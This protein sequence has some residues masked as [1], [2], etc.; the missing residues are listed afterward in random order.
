LQ[1]ALAFGLGDVLTTNYAVL[2]NEALAPVRA[3][4]QSMQRAAGRDEVLTD[5]FARSVQRNAGTAGVSSGGGSH[6]SQM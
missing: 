2:S 6:F 5:L 1:A 4:E 3:L